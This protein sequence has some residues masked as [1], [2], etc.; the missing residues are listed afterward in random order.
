MDKQDI[1]RHAPD[2]KVIIDS[3]RELVD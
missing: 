3:L 1:M 2:G